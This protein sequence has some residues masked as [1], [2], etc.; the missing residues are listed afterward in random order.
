M[1][2][3]LR[4]TGLWSVKI[5]LIYCSLW[6]TMLHICAHQQRGGWRNSMPCMWCF[7][8]WSSC[9]GWY[10]FWGVAPPQHFDLGM[11]LKTRYLFYIF[12]LLCSFGGLKA[13]WIRYLW[14]HQFA[15]LSY[16]FATQQ[17]IPLHIIY[18]EHSEQFSF[19]M[20]V[21]VET[22]LCLPVLQ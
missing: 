6:K 20:M 13:S 12:F 3:K 11:T 18:T 17:P 14:R 22:K 4:T 15:N 19:L 9:P 2:T 1:E 10:V 21:T 5:C 16:P 7:D 8:F